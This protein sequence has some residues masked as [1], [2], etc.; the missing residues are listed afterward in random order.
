[1]HDSSVSAP[2]EGEE[3]GPGGHLDKQHGAPQHVG[4]QVY[5][6]VC[7]LEVLVQIPIPNVSPKKGK[8]KFGLGPLQKELLMLKVKESN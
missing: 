4:H 6:E 1:M 7:R 5:Q 3:G 8:S 2:L